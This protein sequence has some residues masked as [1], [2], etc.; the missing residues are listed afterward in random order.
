M[1]DERNPQNS[2]LLIIGGLLIVVGGWLMAKQFGLVPEPLL[3]GWRMLSAARGAV[4][5]VLIG[6]VVIFLAN[7]GAKIAM[8][9][10]G[11]RLYRSR[12]DKWVS[13]VLGGVAKYFSVDSLLLRLGYLAL[14]FLVN[15]GTALVAYIVLAVV[16]PEEPKVVVTP[17]T[18]AG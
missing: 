16:M 7:R 14:A 13:G 3:A 8:P 5:L 17:P 10:K 1:S 18:Q 4:A 9:E 12:D 6:I 11:T 15:F 2:P